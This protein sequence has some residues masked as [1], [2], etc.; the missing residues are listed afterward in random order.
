MTD[1]KL[2]A[3]HVE[4][5]D[6]VIAAVDRAEAD[7]RAKEINEMYEAFTKRPDA[8]PA[9]DPRW[10]ASVVEWPYDLADHAEDVARGD[11]RWIA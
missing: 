11:D 5:P 10:H 9:V 3:V 2:W 1:T 8:D 6:D 4:G 7:T